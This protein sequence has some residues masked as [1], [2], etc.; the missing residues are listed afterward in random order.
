MRQT[1][2]ANQTANNHS[3]GVVT[4]G[5]SS[6]IGSR[7]PLIGRLL[8]RRL[9]KAVAAEDIN[10]AFSSRRIRPDHGSDAV[11]S[12]M[13]AGISRGVSVLFGEFGSRR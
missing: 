9:R 1:T 8:R 10:D 13:E 2:Q 5:A 4:R 3:T 11:R 12:S 6:G 7:V